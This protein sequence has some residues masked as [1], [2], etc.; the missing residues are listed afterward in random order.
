MTEANQPCNKVATERRQKVYDKVIQRG[1]ERG[2][3][4]AVQGWEIA[5]EIS[6]CPK[7]FTA[8][9]GQIVQVVENK[10]ERIYI[11][12]VQKKYRDDRPRN[13]YPRQDRE[14]DQ[15]RRNERNDQNYKPVE[16]RKPVVEL[17]NPIRI[18]K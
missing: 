3:V 4:E 11:P 5:K 9:T 13:N 2:N 8:L 12:K 7:C 15:V 17:I 14:L 18:V 16:K 10:P 6:C 1:Y